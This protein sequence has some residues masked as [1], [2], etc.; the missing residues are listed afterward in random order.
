MLEIGVTLS[1]L[2]IYVGVEFPARPRLVAEDDPSPASE[3]KL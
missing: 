1:D 2:E 3:G